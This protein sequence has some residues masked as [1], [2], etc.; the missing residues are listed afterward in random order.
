MHKVGQDYRIPDDYCAVTLLKSPL[1]KRQILLSSP[2]FKRLILL[3]TTLYLDLQIRISVETFDKKVKLLSW[4]RIW[5]WIILMERLLYVK[6]EKIMWATHHPETIFSFPVN[7]IYTLRWVFNSNLMVHCKPLDASIAGCL[8]IIDL[9]QKRPGG[10]F[11][12]L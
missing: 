12:Q 5:S 11:T 1:K 8:S 3:D 9:D 7:E 10:V 4:R 6:S 2:W